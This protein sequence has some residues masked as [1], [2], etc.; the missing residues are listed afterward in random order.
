MSELDEI[1]VWSEIKLEILKEYAKAY[2]KILAA[3]KFHHVYI[4]AFAGACKHISRESRKLIPG[5]PLNALNVEPPFAEYYFVDIKG[6]RV[7]ALEQISNDRSNVNVLHGDCNK[8]LLE[9]V[10]PHVK[11][12]DYRR[13]L[14]LLDPYGLD[15]NWKVIETA[16][17]M[18]SIEIFLNF[19]LVDMNRNVLWGKP[20]Q[21]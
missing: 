3:K 21:S 12:E 14:C 7:K 16:G 8:I 13:G 6:I 11:Y 19:P 17:K 18:R 2:S 10:F 1:G 5:S 15:L 4:D 20:R 9:D